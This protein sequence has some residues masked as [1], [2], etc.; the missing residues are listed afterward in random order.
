MVDKNVSQSKVLLDNFS[1][2]AFL[3]CQPE[4]EPIVRACSRV[5]ANVARLGSERSRLLN[6]RLEAHPNELLFPVRTVLWGQSPSL[7]GLRSGTRTT[8]VLT[9]GIGAAHEALMAFLALAAP[10]IP[11]VDHLESRRSVHP[12]IERGAWAAVQFF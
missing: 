3:V 1:R 10:C 6:P 7:L 11:L 5:V 8:V 4:A 2:L 12:L 9:A